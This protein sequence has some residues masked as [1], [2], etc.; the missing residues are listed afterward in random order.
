MNLEIL[1]EDFSS[2]SQSVDLDGLSFQAARF[3]GEVKIESSS[4][5]S[6]IFKLNPYLSPLGLNQK[7]ASGILFSSN[8][9]KIRIFLSKVFSHCGFLGYNFCYN[10]FFKKIRVDET[11]MM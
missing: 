4:S 2:S 11:S 8:I 3:S 1:S 7:V 5:S 6:G 10:F 9:E